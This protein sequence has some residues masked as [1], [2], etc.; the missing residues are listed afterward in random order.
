[1]DS[2]IR[3]I[4]QEMNVAAVMLNAHGIALYH[5]TDA[6][7]ETGWF[8]VPDAIMDREGVTGGTLM[9]YDTGDSIRPATAREH[10]ASVEA[11]EHDGGAGII[12]V[13]I[14]GAIVRCYVAD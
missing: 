3:A 6:S 7:A 9:Q 11:A 13:E 8:P 2:L 4:A 1:M 10:M 12:S 5:Q 14:A